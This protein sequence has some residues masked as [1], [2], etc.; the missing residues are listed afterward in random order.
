MKLFNIAGLGVTLGTLGLLNLFSHA[1]SA[2]DY[3]GNKGVRFDQKTTIEFEFISSDGAYQSTFGVIDLDSCPS[4]AGQTIN[5]IIN[6]ESCEKTPLIREVQ[7]TGN[8]VIERFAEF[9]FEPGRMYAFYLQS[10]INND[11][12]GTVYSTD[13]INPQSNRQALF[14]NEN[15]TFS[16]TEVANRIN[17]LT[18]NINQFDSLLNGG[19]LIRFDDTGSKLV[20]DK[21]QDKDFNDFVVGIGGYEGCIYEQSKNYNP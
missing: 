21:D 13:L 10:T 16:A 12:A 11:P 1:A 15:E 6:D 18:E 3:I 20:K 9:T 5:E 8:T 4:M 17:T 14:S 7:P 19:I 2:A